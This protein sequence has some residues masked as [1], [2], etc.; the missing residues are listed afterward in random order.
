MTNNKKIIIEFNG[1]PG[2]G[3]STVVD[4]LLFNLENTTIPY[5]LPFGKFRRMI[6]ALFDGSVS[7]LFF[8]SMFILKCRS[9]NWKEK[10]NNLLG[11]HYYYQMYLHFV[12]HSSYKYLVVDQGLLQFISSFAYMDKIESENWL[13]KLFKICNKG[14]YKSNIAVINCDVDIDTS[15]SRISK[16]GKPDNSRLDMLYRISPERARV[17]LLTQKTNFEIIRRIAIKAD[18]S[19]FSINLDMSKTPDENVQTLTHKLNLS[20]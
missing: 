18:F 16:R 1:L 20:N 13:I 7:F 4:K 11:A 10:I 8:S 14:I 12:N 5:D 6:S 9:S 2:C 17:A 15:L 19:A 3:K